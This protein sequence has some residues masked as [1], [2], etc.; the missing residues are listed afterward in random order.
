ME[1][2]NG[3]SAPKLLR[4]TFGLRKPPKKDRYVPQLPLQLW[5]RKILEREKSPRRYSQGSPRIVPKGTSLE[6][7]KGGTLFVSQE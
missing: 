6:L 7:P 4:V 1:T 3:P 5:P 2:S